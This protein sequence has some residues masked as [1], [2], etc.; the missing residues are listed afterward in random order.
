MWSLESLGLS[1]T[2]LMVIN[3]KRVPA[4]SGAFFSVETPA[5]RERVIAQVPESGQAD[6]DA[7]VACA[8]V[9]Q[10]EWA[11]RKPAE[12]ALALQRIADAIEED[13]ERLAKI[14]ALETGNAIKTMSRAEVART[15]GNFRYF[16]CLA[17]ETKGLTIPLNN[18][19]L[20]YT[21]REPVGVVAGITPWNGPLVTSS[22]KIAAALVTGNSMVLKVPSYA[23]LAALHVG[24]ICTRFLPPGLLNI[25]TG[26]GATCGEPLAQ[27][28]DVAH[29]TFTGSVEVGRRL[30]T[31]CG[32]RLTS[33]TMELGGK[34]PQII[35]PD[36]EV[37]DYLINTIVGTAAFQRQ[38]Q[39]CIA[40]SRLFIHESLFDAVLDAV[41]AKAK[42]LRIGHP[43]DEECEVGAVTDKVQYNTVCSYIKKGLDS[44]EFRLACGGLPDATGPLSTG[45]YLE[46]TIFVGNNHNALA[47]EEIFGP[48]VVAIPWKTRE[49]VIAM[50][51]DST[52]GLAA[53]IWTHDLS[54]ALDTA[55]QLDAGWIQVNQNGG[56][57]NAQPYGGFKQSGVGKE[58][59]L[60]GMLEAFTRVKTITVNMRY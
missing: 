18:D 14:L 19:V 49:E 13:G 2:E 30:M 42:T 40:G 29:V 32:A 47:R 20:C 35:F 26:P 23:P 8:V 6:V 50:A 54:N 45:Y 16:G 31:L 43:L 34:S 7:A 22:L 37:D 4:Q 24:D 36:V 48:V 55:H 39:A 15:V 44:A 28:P 58:Y 41:V 10:K 21:R 51:N 25:I 11:T 27:H 1:P 56:I 46:P 52:Y 9:A 12:R 59:D 33:S 5:E 3:G 38:G 17:H 53:Y 60:G 57:Q